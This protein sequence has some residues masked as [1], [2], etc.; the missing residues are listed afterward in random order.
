[1]EGS[2]I[3]VPSKTPDLTSATEGRPKPGRSSK[4]GI[5]QIDTS[6]ILFILSGAFEGL[7]KIIDSRVAQ[8]SIGFTANLKSGGDKNSESSMPF[9]TPNKGSTA[10]LLELVEPSD[11]VKYGFIPEFVSRLPT[12]TTL[13]PLTPGDLRRILTDVRGSLVSQYKALFDYSGVD[14]RFTSN[15]LDEIC[16]KAAERGGGAR[17]LRG[18]MD[19]VLLDAMY[20]VPG[21]DIRF[22]L[23]DAGAVRGERPALYWTEREVSAFWAAYNSK[24]T[25][26]RS[27]Q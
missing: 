17:G 12:M 25:G 9:F 6:N 10:N 15:A 5:Y 2:V 1:M 20:E 23:I 21:S 3:S 7:T 19:S 18:I 26:P 27:L 4:P 8:G 22:V 24:E 14:I 13:A 16:M 11:L